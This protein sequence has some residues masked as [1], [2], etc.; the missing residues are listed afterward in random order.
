MAALPQAIPQMAAMQQ[1]PRELVMQLAEVIRLREKGKTIDEAVSAVF[2][3]KEQPAPEPS[4]DMAAL[5]AAQAGA[6]APAAGGPQIA[7][8]QS[9]G[10]DLLMSLAGIT[11]SGNANL[12]SNVSRMETAR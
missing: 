9:P 7:P 11:P 8:P 3:P 6:G 4:P 1:D 12:Q 5:M 2:A 10:Q